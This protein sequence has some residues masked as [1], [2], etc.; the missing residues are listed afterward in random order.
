MLDAFVVLSGRQG[1]GNWNVETVGWKAYGL[2][3]LPTSWVPPFFVLTAEAHRVFR[4]RLKDEDD[5]VSA[6]PVDNSTDG[7]GGRFLGLREV[8]HACSLQRGNRRFFIAGTLRK[9][10]SE[11]PRRCPG[12]SMSHLAST[13]R[14]V[15]C[16]D[17]PGNR[18]N[19]P[20]RP[21]PHQRPNQRPSF[22]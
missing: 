14:F 8:R 10:G 18:S 1:A 17:W 12:S 7:T 20:G 4:G 2:R 9:P 19:A 22:K 6:W 13:G 5:E 3:K 11:R 15:R 21:A 16:R